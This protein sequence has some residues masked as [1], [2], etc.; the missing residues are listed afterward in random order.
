MNHET[1]KPARLFG[2]FEN[3]KFIQRK[4]PKGNIRKEESTCRQSGSGC[5]SQFN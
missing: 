3:R 5:K 1:N 4:H 2:L